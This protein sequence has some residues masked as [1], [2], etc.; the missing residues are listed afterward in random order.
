MKST[1]AC[2]FLTS[3]FLATLAACGGREIV[4]KNDAASSG[5]D[6]GESGVVDSSGTLDEGSRT[7]GVSS[8]VS[9]S[10]PPQDAP[11]HADAPV[12]CTPG[13]SGGSGSGGSCSISATETCSDGTTY[14]GSC[15]CGGGAAKGS[16]FCTGSNGMSGFGGGPYPF[17]DC[18]A[19][20]STDAVWAA[21]GFPH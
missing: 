21:C 18:P 9:D 16:C 12:T 2:F 11:H 19:C 3:G 15:K 10:A 8:G 13:V 17:S 20:A 5:A 6:M 4:Q 7:S 1:L 14:S